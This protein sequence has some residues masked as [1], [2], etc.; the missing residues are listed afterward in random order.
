MFLLN[1]RLIDTT[2]YWR[3]FFV[4]GQRGHKDVLFCKGC[5]GVLG[6]LLVVLLWVSAFFE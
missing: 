4:S 2:E 1:V 5:T 6:V 3:V